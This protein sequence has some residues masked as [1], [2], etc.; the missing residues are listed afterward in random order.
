M[1]KKKYSTVAEVAQ[2]IGIN[3]YGLTVLKYLD[4]YHPDLALDYDFIMERANSG[5]QCVEDYILEHGTAAH[6]QSE[7][8]IRAHEVML[9]DLEFS[10]HS[11]ITTIVDDF[12]ARTSY[13]RGSS[14]LRSVSMELR[15][16]L[17][18]IFAKYPTSDPEFPA[19]CEYDEMVEKLTKKA[20]KLLQKR[21]E[22]PF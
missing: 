18:S 9:S 17:K 3:Y 5:A 11:I 10:E 4:D 22:L 6:F 7:A 21:E 12:Y 20:E 13:A 15:P 19:S 14:E 8:R 16:Q 2:A 1:A